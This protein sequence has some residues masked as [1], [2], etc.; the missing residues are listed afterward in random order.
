MGMQ[1]TAF[2]ERHGVM[3]TLF[4]GELDAVTPLE[5]ATTWSFHARALVK[6]SRMCDTSRPTIVCQMV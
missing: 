6:T 2:D 1:L 3:T 4:V 5:R